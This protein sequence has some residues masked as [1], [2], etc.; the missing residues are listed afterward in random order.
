MTS[1]NVELPN[2]FK[3]SILDKVE[4]NVIVVVIFNLSKSNFLR[5]RN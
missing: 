1:Y 4:K 2:E 5:V 3:P